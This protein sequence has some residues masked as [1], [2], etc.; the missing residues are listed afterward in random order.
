MSAS[1]KHLFQRSL[2]AA[3]DRLHFAAH[4][5]HLWPDASYVGQIAAWQDA[6][7]LADRK[8][9]RVMEELWPAAQHH[10]THELGLP[11]PASIAFAGNT[12][13][14]LIRI[15][16]ALGKSPVRILTSDGEFH[17][18]RRQIARWVEA[19]H[20]E[21]ETVPVGEGFE[22]A[23]LERALSGDHDL[24]FVSQVMFGT[25][26]VTQGLD[27]LAALSRPEGPWLVVDG[28]HGFM[29]V[30]TDLAPLANSAFYLSGGYKYAMAGEGVGILHAPPGFGA[31][32]EITG[33][34]AEFDDLS[35]STGQVGYAPDARRF[36]GATFDPSGLY[37]FVAV[38][39]MLADEGITTATV[40]AYVAGLRDQL[41]GGL[42]DSPLGEAELLNPPGKGSQ[43]RFLAF[44]TPHA[45]KW[46]EMLA[47]QDIVTD[48]RADVLRIGFGLYHDQ[49]DVAELLAV[50][51]R[52][53]TE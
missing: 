13:D 10:V 20:V 1:Y 50:L 34:Y 45:A 41:L 35:L 40:S 21:L 8:W 14:F 9:G 52:L 32:P 44:R 46:Q 23:F 38:R 4:S 15:V 3:P 43:A 49:K 17:S 25:G 7:R 11:D 37:R 5:H 29:A 27:R 31:R 28:Y 12:H 53:P 33:W 22:T 42:D 16:S 47:A 26:R 51:G 39:D 2:A 18:F 6:A 30:E 36:L 19:G 24:I 48:V